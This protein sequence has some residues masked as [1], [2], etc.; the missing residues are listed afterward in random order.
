L[1]RLESGVRYAQALVDT[2]RLNA[3][4]ESVEDV[5]T[6]G[7]DAIEQELHDTGLKRE[8]DALVRRTRDARTNAVDP[9]QPWGL[10]TYATDEELDFVKGL[11]SNP[12]AG[13]VS[14]Y[15]P[16]GCGR[17]ILIGR[18]IEARRQS[19]PT[20]E[21]DSARRVLAEGGNVI[22]YDLDRWPPTL[23]AAVGAFLNKHRALGPRVYATITVPALQFE[24][25]APTLGRLF[26]PECT[27]EVKPLSER[28]MDKL[29]LA[30]GFLIR[31]LRRR[32]V[33]RSR[34]DRIV[35]P[36]MVVFTGQFCSQL[37]MRDIGIGELNTAMRLLAR[38]LRASRDVI[39]VANGVVKL[40]A[41]ALKRHLW[42]QVAQREPP[43]RVVQ[44]KTSAEG[45][46]LPGA[47]IKNADAARVAQLAAEYSS[48]A[49]LAAD[50]GLNRTTLYEAWK[51][52]RVIGV[53]QRAQ[54]QRGASQEPGRREATTR[55]SRDM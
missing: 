15:A 42:A 5:K 3:A 2:G 50:A 26:L 55:A 54:E 6:I 48:L 44:R 19:G 10:S 36:R 52:G 20:R 53:W 46:F 16:P 51:R 45:S 23:H 38:R 27:F 40:T 13:P 49:K 14:V 28:P 1:F 29:M 8:A 37:R 39:F 24:A 33:V 32:P 7:A 12:T 22:L 17:R 35:D 30:R 47:E 34:G 21:I 18:I 43:A 41:E 9:L 25:V 4:R 31:E 11:V